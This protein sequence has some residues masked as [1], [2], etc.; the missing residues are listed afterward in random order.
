MLSIQTSPCICAS[1]LDNAST[2]TLA[3][4]LSSAIK[5]GMDQLNQRQHNQECRQ[6][7][8]II[9]DWLT[10]IDYAPQQSDFVARRQGGT[11]QWLLDS[12][13]FNGWLDQSKQTLFCP[14][15]PGAGKTIIASIV[16]H[17]LHTKFRSDLTV[18]IAYL[19]CNFRQQH[20]QKPTDLLLSLLKQLVQEL[21]SIPESVK[22]LYTHHKDKRT[23]PSFDEISKALHPILADYS[24]SFIIIDALDECQATDG[25]RSKLLSEI[26][27]LQAK[28]GVSLFLTSRYLPEIVK[29]FEGSISLEIRASDED[30]LRYIDGRISWLLR[31][32]ISKYPDLQ[33]TIR[34]EILKAVDGMYDFVPP[35]MMHRPY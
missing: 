22:N 1:W 25:G 24:R 21:P 5:D 3:S 20:E 35:D 33:N 17:H 11:G 18:G 14:G 28:T 2:L 29:E 15:I 19:Y 8:Q 23:R 4:E 12:K 13:E 10:P 27:N 6:E 9:A 30:V 26:L 16:V 32:R 31:S 34:K 7:H